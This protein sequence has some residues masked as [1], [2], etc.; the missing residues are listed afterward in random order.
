MPGSLGAPDEQGHR[1]SGLFRLT[2]RCG[3][4]RKKR[5]AALGGAAGQEQEARLPVRSLPRRL[6]RS[7]AGD[8]NAGRSELLSRVS[9]RRR[10]R[11]A[12]DVICPGGAPADD[13]SCCSR[14]FL[15]TRRLLLVLDGE[16]IPCRRL[17]REVFRPAA[18][19]ALIGIKSGVLARGRPGVKKC[20]PQ[21]GNGRPA[22]PPSRIVAGRPPKRAA[23]RGEIGGRPGRTGRRERRRRAAAIAWFAEFGRDGGR[24]AVPACG[25]TRPP[26]VA[27]ARSAAGSRP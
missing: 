3:R 18:G 6:T 25:V 24:A 10:S 11:H 16:G 8:R 4:G 27:A 22:R 20:E 13:G 21:G 14:S 7:G 19:A 17:L 12:V 5:P 15:R 1:Q 26:A 2:E 9:R 23:P